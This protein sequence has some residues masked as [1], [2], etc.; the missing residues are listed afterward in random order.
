M[1]AEE[2][3]PWAAAAAEAD[4]EE[5]ACIPTVPSSASWAANWAAEAASAASAADAS[6]VLVP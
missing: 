5:E 4:K 1:S 2:A 6:A 3:A